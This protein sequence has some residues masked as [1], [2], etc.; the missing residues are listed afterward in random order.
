MR[1]LTTLA[2]VMG[3]ITGMP[4]RADASTI[5]DATLLGI[6]E[7]PPNFSSAFGTAE[8][9]Q[10]GDFLT[11]QETFTGLT[12]SNATAA[13]IHCCGPV[14]TNT[15][16]AV[17]FFG[18]PNATAGTYH[19]TFDLTL[20]ATYALTFVTASGGTAAMA[21]V[22]LLAGL[23]GGDAYEN[24]HDGLFLGGEIRGQFAPAAA[25]AVPEPATMTL[26]GLGLA[27]MAARRRRGRYPFSIRN[28]HCRAASVVAPQH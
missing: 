8:L 2:L 7:L 15:I 23:S 17:P 22:A 20:L 21:E 27:G 18:F 14:G 28:G 6:N 24:I 4:N 10:N 25:A 13:H 19:Q 16:V 1:F 26:F 12:G 5:Y 11:V 9:T 3:L